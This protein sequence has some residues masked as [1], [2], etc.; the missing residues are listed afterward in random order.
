M[1]SLLFFCVCVFVYAT[2][3]MRSHYW[4]NVF[5]QY[6]DIFA[7]Q[8][9]FFRFKAAFNVF[10][11]RPSYHFRSGA[12]LVFLSSLF[13]SYSCSPILNLPLPL[14]LLLNFPLYP[15]AM[16]Y[17][18]LPLTFAF[19]CNF[20]PTLHAK[21]ISTKI[22]LT[23][24][25]TKINR[26]LFVGLL[27]AFQVIILFIP[28]IVF[29]KEKFIFISFRL[30]YYSELIP[31]NMHAMHINNKYNMCCICP[32]MQW[33]ET[34]FSPIRLL[35]FLLL[36]LLYICSRVLLSWSARDYF[37][38]MQPHRYTPYSSIISFSLLFL[39]LL[40][41]IDWLMSILPY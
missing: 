20:W 8:L 29:G 30:I 34:H 17:P 38:D 40:L 11:R 1:V 13:L 7:F 24:T 12:F 9:R 22:W 37:T 16:E 33:S 18:S 15:S 26:F 14:W 41:F 2:Y 3:W 6:F 19:K 31:M 23:Q 4:A 25:N 32:C 27:F 39:L 10:H 35:F 21:Q 5:R 28:S 36:L